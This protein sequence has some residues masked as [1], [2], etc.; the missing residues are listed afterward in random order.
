MT[1]KSA[2]MENISIEPTDRSPRVAFDFQAG[3]LRLEGESFPEDSAAFFAPLLNAVRGF[4]TEHSQSP[5]TLDVSMV[6]FNS[7]SAK[8]L[9]NLF[10]LLEQA[11]ADGRPVIVNWHY[12]PDDDTMEEFGED[13]GLDFANAEFRMCPTE[14]NS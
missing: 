1:G 13:F 6:Y 9:M 11:A 3:H 4:L 8:A 5:V 10:Q 12:H 14:A 7:S 2:T